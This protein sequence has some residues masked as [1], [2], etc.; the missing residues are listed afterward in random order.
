MNSGLII[1]IGLIIII[2]TADIILIV[3]YVNS[4]EEK[5]NM[6]NELCEN[7]GF[8]KHQLNYGNNHTGYCYNINEDNVTK[9]DFFCQRETTNTTQWDKCVFM[10]KEAKKE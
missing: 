10:E 5:G 8:E 3:G 4:V 7:A 9:K 2:G 6:I 1:G